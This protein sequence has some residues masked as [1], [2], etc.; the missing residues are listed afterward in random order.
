MVHCKQISIERSLTAAIVS[1]P[2]ANAVKNTKTVYSVVVFYI[3]RAYKVSDNKVKRSKNY[4]ADACK[5][6]FYQHRH[7]Q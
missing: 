7:R 4:K 5:K 2:T 1:M 3:I 6:Q